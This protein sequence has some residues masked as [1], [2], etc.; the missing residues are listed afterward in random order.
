MA[1]IVLRT[2]RAP[3]KNTRPTSP[4]DNDTFMKVWLKE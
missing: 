4:Y 2:G 3:T 1:S